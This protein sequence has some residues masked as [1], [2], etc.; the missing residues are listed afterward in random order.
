MVSLVSGS[1]VTLPDVTCLPVSGFLVVKVT[2]PPYVVV[3]VVLGEPDGGA[4]SNEPPSSG[5]PAAAAPIPAT[6]FAVLISAATY[7]LK[8]AEVTGI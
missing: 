8:S 3:V 6:S 5:A 4:P 7:P 1:V 2:A